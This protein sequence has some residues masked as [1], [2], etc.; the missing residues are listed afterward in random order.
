MG[1]KEVIPSSLLATEAPLQKHSRQ[2]DKLTGFTLLHFQISLVLEQSFHLENQLPEGWAIPRKAILPQV[3]Q[4]GTDISN[5]HRDGR[6]CSQEDNF[7]IL[8]F[9]L[10]GKIHIKSS[11]LCVK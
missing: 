3:D 11:F 7:W 9:F 2:D 8:A 4:R 1:D 6:P 5:L 10:Y